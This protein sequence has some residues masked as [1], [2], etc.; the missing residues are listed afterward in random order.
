[1]EPEHP[2]EI[3]GVHKSSRVKFQTKQYYLPIST[4]FKYTV[5]MYQVE[6]RGALHTD[7]H[8]FFMKIKEEQTE[9]TTV[10]MT[11]LSLKAGLKE[12]GN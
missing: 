11:Q 9:T 4:G 2:Y 10:I 8:M 12:G 6:D 5:A 1:M 3:P 7:A